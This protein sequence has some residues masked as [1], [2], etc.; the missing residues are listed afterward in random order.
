MTLDLGNNRISD[1]SL[2]GQFKNLKELN[3][4]GNPLQKQTLWNLRRLKILQTLTVDSKFAKFILRD[5]TRVNG[6]AA[7]PVALDK[8]T[9]LLRTF[10]L[11]NLKS[12]VVNIARDLQT[13]QTFDQHTQLKPDF[14]EVDDVYGTVAW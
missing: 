2:I 4:K 1:L 11:L 7:T 6:K 14:E 5:Y 10:D 3:L 13:T 9:A 12:N 8:I